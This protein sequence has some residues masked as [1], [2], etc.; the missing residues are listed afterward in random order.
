VFLVWLWI[1]NVAVLL[2]VTF[3]AELARGRRIEQ[4]QSPDHEPVLPPR[5][6]PGD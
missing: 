6:E 3:D 5:D 2:G 4:G 1:T